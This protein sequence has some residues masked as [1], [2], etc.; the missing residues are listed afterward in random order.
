MAVFRFALAGYI[1]LVWFLSLQLKLKM[2]KPLAVITLII[3][4][5]ALAFLAIMTRAMRINYGID[6]S[7]VESNCALVNQN[8]TAEGIGEVVEIFQT[9]RMGDD[10]LHQ[11][12]NMKMCTA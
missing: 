9:A 1:C 3:L 10:K 8:K 2:K 4:C 7:V 6:E 11:L 5:I 12:V